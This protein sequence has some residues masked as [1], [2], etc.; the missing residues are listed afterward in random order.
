[1][2]LLF[3][4]D[5]PPAHTVYVSVLSLSLTV[6]KCQRKGL[7]MLYFLIAHLLQMMVN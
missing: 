6:L 3:H 2:A 4:R 5:L 1:M 7:W